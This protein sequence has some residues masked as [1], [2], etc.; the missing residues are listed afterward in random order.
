MYGDNFQIGNCNEVGGDQTITN[1][2]FMSPST[3]S[4]AD[5]LLP[6]SVTPHCPR[7][8]DVPLDMLSGG[9][10]GRVQEIALI[11]WSFEVQR[12][13]I[14][15]RCAIYGMCGIGKSQASYA[16]AKDLF[17]QGRYMNIF[18][19]QASSDEKLLHSFA[20]SCLTPRSICSRT[21]CKTHSRPALAGGL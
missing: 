17:N 7:F 2:Y 9:F 20:P 3:S 21:R 16:L 11:I 5:P 13:D 19:V 15:S 6:S 12:G 14:P 4:A 1:Y 8:N 18:Y 10:T